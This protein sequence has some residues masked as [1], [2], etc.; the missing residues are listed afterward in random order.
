MIKKF[1]KKVTGIE[2]VEREKAQALAEAAEIKRQAEEEALRAIQEAEEAK[3]KAIQAAY[4]EK[5]ARM[6]PKERATE[7]GEPF[8]EVSKVHLD[9]N[10]MNGGYLEFDWNELF[11]VNLRANGYGASGDREEE[12]VDRWYRDI[13][14][15]VAAEMDIDT[16]ERMYG[17]IN[18]KPLA[19]NKSEVS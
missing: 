15:N 9:P 17:Y 3:E 10:K 11:I 1:F 4:E 6:S 14:Y 12:I 16:D 18:V 7:L 13:C 8:I 2:K 19:D 5:L